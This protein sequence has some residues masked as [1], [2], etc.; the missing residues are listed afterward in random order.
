MYLYLS[1]FCFCTKLP[2]VNGTLFTCPYLPFRDIIFCSGSEQS[3]DN[4]SRYHLRAQYRD[5]LCKDGLGMTLTVGLVILILFI[6]MSSNITTVLQWK[7][8]FYSYNGYTSAFVV[9]GCRIR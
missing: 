4:W 9:V 1:Q 2:A 3:E 5:I 6:S 8:S 7:V